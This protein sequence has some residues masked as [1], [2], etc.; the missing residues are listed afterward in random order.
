MRH[1][2]CRD[3]QSY[4]IKSR[5][6]FSFNNSVFFLLASHCF[7]YK[8]HTDVLRHNYIDALLGRYNLSDRNEVDLKTVLIEDSKI[9]QD[10]NISPDN[11]DADIAIIRS[12][13][14]LILKLINLV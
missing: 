2:V 13:G 1:T 9:N 4:R 8:H 12:C 3:S 6:L 10:W 14:S 7:Q 5:D 11:F